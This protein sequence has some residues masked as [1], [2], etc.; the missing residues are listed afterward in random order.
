[1]LKVAPKYGNWRTKEQR[2]G[3]QRKASVGVRPFRSLQ[4]RKCGHVTEEVRMH[5]ALGHV[6]WGR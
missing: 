1:M 3:G 4:T 6:L 2:H 5:W